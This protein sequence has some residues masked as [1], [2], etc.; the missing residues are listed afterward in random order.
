M[1]K[2]AIENCMRP[3]ENTGDPQVENGILLNSRMM[4]DN[5]DSL[6]LL[7]ATPF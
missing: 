7:K 4:V 3:K 2:E 1:D 5:N 6:G